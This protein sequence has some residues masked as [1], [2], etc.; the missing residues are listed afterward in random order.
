MVAAG[1]LVARLIAPSIAPFA[2]T[3]LPFR[4]RRDADLYRA[5]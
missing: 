1:A 3:P 2:V 5:R 4:S